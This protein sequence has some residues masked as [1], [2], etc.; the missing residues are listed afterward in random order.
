MNIWK[1]KIYGVDNSGRDNFG[2]TLAQ[3]LRVNRDGICR[4]ERRV[5]FEALRKGCMYR[6]GTSVGN[7]YDLAVAS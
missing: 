6:L 7:W 3:F 1:L 5:I 4:T 2:C